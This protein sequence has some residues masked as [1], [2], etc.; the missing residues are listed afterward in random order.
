MHRLLVLLCGRSFAGKTTVA[1]RL[2]D[3]AEFVVVSL[4]G[5]NARR[6]LRSGAGLSVDA[7]ERTHQIAIAETRRVLRETGRVVVDDTSS[8]R[9]L[10]DR[11]RQVAI[12]ERAAFRLVLLEVETSEWERRRE[13]VRLSQSRPDVD[14]EVLR[15]HLTSFQDPGLDED[16]LVI[17]SDQEPRSWIGSLGL[18]NGGVRDESTR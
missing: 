17:R 16:A 5:I 12:E 7:W 13:Q 4:D 8:L 18:P 2:R 1:S 3:S 15:A 9:F 14:D 10:R 6:G 11:W